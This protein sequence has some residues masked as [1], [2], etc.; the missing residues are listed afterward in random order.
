MLWSTDA[1]A[2]AACGLPGCCPL[3]THQQQRCTPIPLIV[4]KEFETFFPLHAAVQHC[5]NRWKK[6]SLLKFSCSGFLH[7]KTPRPYHTGDLFTS[8]VKRGS[9][10]I[11]H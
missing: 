1:K 9:A 11:F 2:S 7:G 6:P 4:D 8:R 5:D 10:M 3:F